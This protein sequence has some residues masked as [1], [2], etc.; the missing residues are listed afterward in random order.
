MASPSCWFQATTLAV[1]VSVGAWS[2]ALV[3]EH[4]D[5]QQFQLGTEKIVGGE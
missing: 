2:V 3:S 1:M 4:V 5:D